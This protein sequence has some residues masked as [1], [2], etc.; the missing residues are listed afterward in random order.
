MLRRSQGL[1]VAIIG[2]GP[3]GSICARL[4]ARSGARVSLI[5]RGNPYSSLVELVSGQSRRYLEE[6]LGDSLIEV[7]G[8]T[9]VFQTISLWD[10]PEPVVWNAILNP[11]GR[12]V[13][14]SRSK[15]DEGLCHAASQAGATVLANTTVTS[16]DRT[17][18]GWQLFINDDKSRR[19]LHASLLVIATGRASGYL[20]G[21]NPTIIAPQLA[22]MAHLVAKIIK[23]DQS[24]Y[25]EATRNGWWYAMPDPRGGMFAGYCTKNNTNIK[26]RGKSLQALW[27]EELHHTR[28]IIDLFDKKVP[29]G[30]VLG[31][32]A[33][34]YHFDKISGARWVAV[35]DAAFSLDPLSGKGIEFATQ[36]AILAA[37]SLLGQAQYPALQE[38]DNWVCEYAR[39][40]EEARDIYFSQANPY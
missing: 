21:R 24:L 25:L 18:S 14:V 39:R 33:S 40:E 12:G 13:A 36:S 31:R 20:L 38:Y 17:P 16:L 22:L 10:T 19:I 11:W 3:A 26:R 30:P 4:L 27:F 34:M 23:S 7:V 6:Q 28:L 32:P 35:G 15:F 37:E 1:D 5:D 9:E 8:G 2:G 29:G